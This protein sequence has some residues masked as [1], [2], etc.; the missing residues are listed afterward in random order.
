MRLDAH[1]HAARQL[2]AHRAHR[3]AQAVLAGLEVEDLQAHRAGLRLDVEVAAHA[4]TRHTAGVSR[5]VDHTVH[6]D[7]VD[8]AGV[9]LHTKL[10]ALQVA[11]A[12]AACIGLHRSAH[13]AGHVH[14]RAALPTPEPVE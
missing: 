2:D 13:I 10:A 7:Q 11:H 6:I 5:E 4:A 8:L 14:R 1:V 12:H 3:G 9:G